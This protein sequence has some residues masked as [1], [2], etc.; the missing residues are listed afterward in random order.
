MVEQE[1][2]IGLIL[3]G[4]LRSGFV[5]SFYS[6]KPIV[7]FGERGSL[8]ICLIL[9]LCVRTTRSCRRHCLSFR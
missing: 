3:G 9:S 7:Y 4:F 5:M 1:T 6:I 8:S 2:K